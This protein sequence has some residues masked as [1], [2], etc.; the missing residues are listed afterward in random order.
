[1]QR[2]SENRPAFT[3]AEPGCKV[4]ARTVSQ[5]LADSNTFELLLPSPREG[6][7]LLAGHC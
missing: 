4:R 7:Y 6:H 2:D 3:P 1:M 5:F